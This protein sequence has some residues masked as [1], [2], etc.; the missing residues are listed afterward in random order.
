MAK[1]KTLYI[2]AIVWPTQDST[3]W[4]LFDLLKIP[5]LCSS[6]IE[7]V[8]AYRSS[9]FPSHAQHVNAHSLHIIRKYCNNSEE[10]EKEKKGLRLK[11]FISKSIDSREKFNFIFTSIEAKTLLFWCSLSAVV[12]DFNQNCGHITIEFIGFKRYMNG[13]ACTFGM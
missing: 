4:H 7:M 11:S 3:L 10:R 8:G 6:L 13:N 2:L 5:F 1:Y 9:K 12:L